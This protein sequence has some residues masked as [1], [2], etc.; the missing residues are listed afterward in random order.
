MQL[1]Y[2]NE[3][4]SRIRLLGLSKDRG[5]RREE[6]TIG[7]HPRYKYKTHKTIGKQQITRT[8]YSTQFNIFSGHRMRRGGLA[9]RSVID[10]TQCILANFRAYRLLDYLKC[11]G[12]C[13]CGWVGGRVHVCIIINSPRRITSYR[14]K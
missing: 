7:V 5:H 10:K 3:Y 6:E 2:S 4:F 8:N 11:I 12:V 1:V 13:V 9:V 14:D